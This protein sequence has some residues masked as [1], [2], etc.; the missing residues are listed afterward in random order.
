M[1]SVEDSESAAGV[2]AEPEMEGDTALVTPNEPAAEFTEPVGPE[3]ASAD[4]G[5]ADAGDADEQE[6]DTIARPNDEYLVWDPVRIHT[7]K[8]VMERL[9]AFAESTRRKVVESGSYQR[10]DGRS[11]R[12]AHAAFCALLCARMRVEMRMYWGHRPCRRSSGWWA[13]LTSARAPP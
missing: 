8:E 9:R 12:F 2:D 13:A 3:G 10:Q 5:G 6:P 1:D 11:V 4:A 7:G